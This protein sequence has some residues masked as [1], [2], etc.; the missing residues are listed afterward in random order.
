MS[1]NNRLSSPVQLAVDHSA[2][3][4]PPDLQPYFQ[5]IHT[6]LYTLVDALTRYCGI[7]SLVDSEGQSATASDTIVAGNNGRFWC[8]AAEVI[9]PG[10]LITLVNTSG[11]ITAVKADAGASKP[12]DGIYLGS[13]ATVVGTRYEFSLGYGIIT[14]YSN[15]TVGGNYYLGAGGLVQLGSPQGSGAI[16][17]YVGR[18][19]T[20]KLIF[21]NL[22]PPMALGV[23]GTAG[24]AVRWGA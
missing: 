11:V 8:M 14:N 4:C 7:D 20:D 6:S 21:M 9:S 23:P 24:V 16:S 3:D 2:T 15:L 13:A 17:Q 19:L 22:G 18:A 10:Q 5:R 1:S 12:A